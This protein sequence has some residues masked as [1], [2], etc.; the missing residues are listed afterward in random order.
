MRIVKWMLVVLVLVIAAAVVAVLTVDVN[1]FKPQIVTAV[2]NATGRKLDIAEDMKLSLFP[3][4]VTVKKV[5]FSNAAWGSRPQM[6]TIGEFTAQVDLFAL[7]GRQIK[8]DRLVLTDVDLLA[9]KNRQGQAN[10]EFAPPSGGAGTAAQPTQPPVAESGSSFN[11]LPVISDVLL[12]NVKL[13][14]RDAQSGAKNDLL[15]RQLS[16]KQAKGDTLA[17]KLSADVDG[18][19]IAAE[20]TLGSL[21]ELMGPSRPWPVKLAVTVPGATVNVDGSIAQPM[22]AKGL[23]LR[24][25]AEAPDLA[26]LAQTFGAAAPA[27]PLQLMVAVK[28]NGPQDY[29]LSD[30]TGKIGDSDLSGNGEIAL[31]GTRP[32]LKFD[33]ASKSTNLVPLLDM[34]GGDSKPATGGG[35]SG[36]NAAGGGNG[37]RLFSDDPLPLD[38]LNAVD[39]VLSYKAADF[40]APKLEA[41]NLAVSLTLKDGVLNVKPFTLDAAGGHAEG[42]VALNGKAKTLA[43]K[44]DASKIDLSGYLKQAGVTDIIN[45]GAP[46]DLAVDVA[47][48][49]ASLHQLMAALDG[50]VILKVGEGELKE[51]YMKSFLPQLADAVGILGR[52]TA[53]TKLY[54]VVSGLDIKKGVVTPKSLLA[55]SGR[56]S[57]TG[58]GEVNLG[59]EQ[60]SM[61]VVPSSRDVSLG[62]ALPP[63]RVR[64][65]LTGPSFSPDPAALAKSVIGTAAGIAALGPL[66]I[67]SPVLGKSGG[68]DSATACAKAVALAEGKPLPQSSGASGSGSQPPSTP[69]QELKDLGSKLKG[70]LGR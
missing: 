41:K 29:V 48:T 30:I 9:E 40:K 65:P 23:A 32:S 24:I 17:V 64:G 43:V 20:G 1:R 63:V 27:V 45:T 2:E 6:A 61:L 16:V 5:S 66:A 50:T 46:T 59:T 58:Q 70:L 60:V 68:D 34:K 39:A 54:C 22:Q 55:E 53:K 57:L 56:I 44:L 51:D 35:G 31:G 47:S 7:L 18:N 36:G 25:I 69:Q 3:L 11:G 14:Y 67:L 28:D 37:G 33:L 13:A 10:W 38:G 15:L 19:E 42:S 8:I 49:G 21:A 52:A 12:K 62:A 4:G 26:K